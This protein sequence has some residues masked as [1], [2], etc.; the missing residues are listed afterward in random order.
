MAHKAELYLISPDRPSRANFD[1]VTSSWV[2]DVFSLQAAA[3]IR[4][5]AKH[6]LF[7]FLN[8]GLAQLD[9]IDLKYGALVGSRGGGFDQSTPL[10]PAFRLLK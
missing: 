7:V 4:G 1:C 9:S 8:G 5:L 3:G 6:C 2:A 10:S